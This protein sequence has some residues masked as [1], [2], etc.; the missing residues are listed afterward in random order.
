[1]GFAE[2]LRGMLGSGSGRHQKPARPAG[3]DQAGD[4][5]PDDAQPTDVR[6][7]DTQPNVMQPTDAQ[8][9]DAQPSQE[10]RTDQAAWHAEEPAEGHEK[11]AADPREE[12][13][14]AADLVRGAVD[15]DQ[16]PA[17]PSTQA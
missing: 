12:P 17:G 2:K 9:T 6:P 8:P 16:D 10:A 14:S 4:A 5:R 1:M 11:H 7:D 3:A 15:H 13:A